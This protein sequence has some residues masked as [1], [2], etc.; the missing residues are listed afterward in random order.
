MALL[1]TEERHLVIIE[2]LDF[3][4]YQLAGV[5]VTVFLF[6]N[7][8]LK[9]TFL[10]R[11]IAF[12][13]L[14]FFHVLSGWT[15]RKVSSG[16]LMRIG[17]VSGAI[18]FLLLFL[19]QGRAIQYIIPLAYLTDLVQEI[20]GQRWHGFRSTKRLRSALFYRI[21]ASGSYCLIYRQITV[22]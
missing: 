14:L 4:A 22:P 10:Y 17:V 21:P 11:L 18:Y 19:L 7:S 2:G 9:T 12:T 16:S 5:F 6:T 20:T 8:D 3:F 15:L 13:S 1:N